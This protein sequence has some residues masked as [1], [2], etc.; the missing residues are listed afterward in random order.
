MPDASHSKTKNVLSI[1]LPLTGILIC[2]LWFYWDFITG[3]VFGW[4]DDLYVFYPGANYF[5]RS[6]ADGVFPFWLPGLRCGMPFYS[7][8][9]MGLF[10][11]LKWLLVLFVKDGELPQQAYQCYLVFQYM[12][13]GFLFF[14]L[15]RLHKSPR[16]AA[17]IGSLVYCFSGFT[18]LHIIFF[19][20]IEVMVWL[21]LVLM[22]IK[23]YFNQKSLFR[24]LL[25]SL[26]VLMT[27][28]PGFPQVTLYVSYFSIAYWLVLAVH[29]AQDKGATWKGVLV[30]A[31]REM[32]IA[33]GVFLLAIAMGAIAFLPGFENW[34]QSSRATYG[35][36]K[37]ADTSMPFYYMVNMFF[38]N[39]T[40]TMKPVGDAVQYWGFNKDT[41]GFEMYKTAYW[42]FWDLSCYAGQIGIIALLYSLVFIRSFLKMPFRLVCT[43]AA[44]FALWFMLGRY[45]GLFKVLYEILPGISAFRGP[46]RMSCVL[47][48]SQAVLAAYFVADL[49]RGE[50]L[51]RMRK[52]LLVILGG[53]LAFLVIFLI[54]GKE[55]A[56]PFGNAKIFAYSVRQV[57]V[58][59]GF[60][61]SIVAVSFLV[62]R[63]PLEKFKGVIF[64]VLFLS[65]FLDLYSA[66]GSFFKGEQKASDYYAGGGN[67]IAQLQG[68]NKQNG[69]Y[70][71]GQVNNGRLH[72][73]VAL[74][75][76]TGF[77]HDLELPEG[78][79]LF[80]L[81]SVARVRR[82]LPEETVRDLLNIGVI[83][84]RT[85]K[86]VEMK[87]R[88]S[89]FPRASL[90]RTATAFE[91]YDELFDA[92]SA[93]GFDYKE[94][95][96]LLQAD[97][98]DE[99]L[100]RLQDG[101]RTPCKVRKVNNNE[102]R[103]A[104]PSGDAGILFFSQA[105][106]PGWKAFGQDGQE[107]DVIEVFGG[108]TG[109]VIPG[110]GSQEITLSFSP[111]LFVKG[112][113]ISTVIILVVL[114]VL[115]FLFV[116]GKKCSTDRD[117]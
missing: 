114:G 22:A 51:P 15:M 87:V 83:A 25:I 28:L 59:T 7:D 57:L 34:Q 113:I 73:M 23:F 89:L 19:A 116:R 11:P 63:K 88:G 102:W 61:A 95:I 82:S 8:I 55:W 50:N 92:V 86:G 97:I 64:S 56:P 18:A 74:P 5:A 52:F 49:I 24:L 103:I 104:H 2:L 77:I 29:E 65:V 72:E 3:K 54:G 21:P 91:T 112:A 48:A 45:G 108:L 107:F 94:N 99:V 44:V 17:A 117:Q 27:F 111:D 26:A 10:Y 13:G 106:Y 30:G 60:T 101:G 67:L 90:Y 68:F 39:F 100:G 109:I 32:A 38:P 33:A 98:D 85:P 16:A 71:F 43:L 66:H 37:V 47:N 84:E 1:L 40:G 35:Y 110:A 41:L 96:A 4:D 31:I 105:H 20:S 80:M 115:V 62:G 58:G 12:V 46:G 36:D 42:H 79:N 76:N 93:S 69:L 53:Y 70:R 78:Y 75:R 14:G 81:S 9:Q 6:I